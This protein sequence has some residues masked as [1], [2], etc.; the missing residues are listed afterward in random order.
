MTDH[1]TVPMFLQGM[2]TSV[3]FKLQKHF[4]VSNM[5]D[6]FPTNLLSES[7]SVSVTV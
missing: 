2:Y 4:L 5:S 1:V 7:E 3:L 6:M